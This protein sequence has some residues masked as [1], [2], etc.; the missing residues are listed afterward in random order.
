MPSILAHPRT[1]QVPGHTYP[2]TDVLTRPAPP[3]DVV[4]RY[5]DHPDHVIDLRLPAVASGP[6]VIFLHGGF[7]RAAYDRAHTGPLAADLVARGYPVACP[8]YRRVGQPGG[9]WPGTLDDVEAALAA[10][11]GLVRPHAD[12]AG[13]ILAGHSAGGH[14]ALLNAHTPG[15]AGVVALAPVADLAA[16][17]HAG[18]GSHAVEALLGGGPHAVPR[19]FDRADP[20]RRGPL[21]VPTVIIHGDADDRVPLANSAGYAASV[22]GDLCRIEVLS[23]IDHFAVIDPLSEAWP[24]VVIALSRIR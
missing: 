3:P 5:G 12:P 13:A 8:E 1:R 7:W 24:S 18:I 22:G 10:L 15:L 9:G 16:A 20:A 4:L 2:V 17:H 11:S 21:P 23:G 14:L 19:H 6:L